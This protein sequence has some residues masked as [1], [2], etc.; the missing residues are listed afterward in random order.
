MLNV[1]KK[2]AG[3]TTNLNQAN[4]TFEQAEGDL[5]D[6]QTAATKLLMT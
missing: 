3:A 2:I 1:Q 5:L 4:A 6:A